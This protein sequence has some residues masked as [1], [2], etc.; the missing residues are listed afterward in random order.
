MNPMSNYLA[1]TSSEAWFHSKWDKPDLATKILSFSSPLDEEDGNNLSDG[2]FAAATDTSMVKCVLTAYAL[3][4]L[5]YNIED[6]L[7]L[8]I[9]DNR[10]KSY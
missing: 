9:I 5:L 3:K 10:D 4:A 6:Y 8:I 7:T 2:E 1:L